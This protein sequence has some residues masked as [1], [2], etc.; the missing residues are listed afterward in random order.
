MRYLKTLRC[1]TAFSASL[2]IIIIN[3]LAYST[4]AAAA[5]AKGYHANGNPQSDTTALLG[6]FGE[7]IDIDVRQ[8]LLAESHLMRRSGDELAEAFNDSGEV[9]DYVSYV[10]ASRL[11]SVPRQVKGF[12]Q[13]RCRV[14]SD[15]LKQ[16]RTIRNAVEDKFFFDEN[17]KFQTSVQNIYDAAGLVEAQA[18]LLSEDGSHCK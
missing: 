4:V 12:V 18:M 17:R 6:R 5:N 14:E 8:L 2:T 9:I 13:P 10:R 3:V 11:A 16:S 7:L 15:A 1:V